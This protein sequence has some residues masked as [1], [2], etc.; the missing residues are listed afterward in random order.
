MSE[1][2]Q[3][4]VRLRKNATHSIRW[5]ARRSRELYPETNA[6]HISHTYLRQIEQGLQKH[7]S[8]EKLR[9]LAEIYGADYEILLRLA[10]YLTESTTSIP[11][12]NALVETVVRRLRAEG[13]R[14]E[15]FLQ[16][17]ADLSSDSLAIVSRLIT[18]LSIQSKGRKKG[19]GARREH[20]E[21]Q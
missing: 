12:S 15:Y 4:L 6:R 9:T 10:G 16:A 1:L 18:T 14:P 3:E 19:R 7:P 17:V 5:V 11:H 8:P 20:E 21:A 13:I 2:G